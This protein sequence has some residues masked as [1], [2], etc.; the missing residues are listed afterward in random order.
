MAYS[1]IKIKSKECRICHK[2]VPLFSRG[3]CQQCTKRE[4]YKPLK[5]VS[6]KIKETPKQDSRELQRWFED[7]HNEMTGICAHCQKGSSKGT[8]QYKCSIAHIL[9][10]RLFKSVATHSLNWIELC[11]WGESCHSNYDNYI[12]DITELNC[13]D[14]VIERFLAMYP[15]ID[16]KERKYIPDVLMNY[17]NIDI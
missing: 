10:K 13:F 12:L 4:D 16:K 11:F 7:R 9:P 14:L 3:R 8:A 6:D 15:S 2:I 5:K 1:T 17:V